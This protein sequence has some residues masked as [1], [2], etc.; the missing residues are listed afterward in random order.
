MTDIVYEVSIDRTGLLVVEKFSMAINYIYPVLINISCKHR[1]VR[2]EAI[3]ALLQQ[4][5]LFYD[6]AKSDQISKLYLADSGLAYVKEL[7]RFLVDKNRKLISLKQYDVTLIHIAETG[8]ILGS[9]IR[10]KSK[11]R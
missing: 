7:L 6:A 8:N 9:W 10:S 5:K 11:K 1:V 4:Q 2:D 3:S